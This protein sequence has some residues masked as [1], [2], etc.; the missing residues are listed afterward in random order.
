MRIDSYHA[1]LNNGMIITN[2]TLENE[3]IKWNKMH[4]S[5]T[6]THVKKNRVE[7]KDTLLN[8]HIELETQ[9][10]TET[11]S[12]QEIDCLEISLEIEHEQILA[13]YLF[14]DW[15]T[16]PLFISSFKE[17]PEQTTVLFFKN[18]DIYTCMLALPGKVFRAH[19]ASGDADNQVKLVLSS[20]SAGYS[21]IEETSLVFE[22]DAN[23]YNCFKK[24]I[25][26]ACELYHIP[27]RADRVY[28]SLFEKIGW[29]SWDAFYKEVNEEKLVKKANEIKSKQIPFGWILIDDGWQDYENDQM[30]SYKTN[31]VKFPNELI[32]VVNKIEDITGID[33]VGVWH[34]F[35]GYWSGVHPTG[36][37]LKNNPDLFIHTHQGKIMP[38]PEKA[39]EFF[40]EWYEYLKSQKISFVKVDSQSST[41]Q[42]YRS[43]TPTGLTSKYLHEG[44][45][46]ASETYMDGNL[47]NCMGMALEDVLQ[48][49]I[50]GLSRN[51]D[52]FFPLEEKSFKEHLLEN[53]Y[54]SLY[55]NYIYYADWDM[56]WSNHK[57]AN[58]HALLRALS[59]GPIYVS[60]KI[61]ETIPEVLMPTCYEDGTILRANQSA[62]PTVDCILMDPEKNGYLKIQN[63][64]NGVGYMAIYSYLNR[65]CEVSIQVKDISLL[66][67]NE[68]Y[69]IYNPMDKVGF[70]GNKET[71]WNI[72][73]PCEGYTFYQIAPIIDGIAVFGRSDKYLSSHAIKR[74]GSTIRLKESGP[75]LFY[76]EKEPSMHC[77]NLG[78][79]FY[80]IQLPIDKKEIELEI[81]R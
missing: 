48:R 65:D 56:F 75:V 15:W 22:R 72:Q 14:K 79:H 51:S 9:S 32:S 7:L 25:E 69:A 27:I 8:V 20:D 18:K 47:I 12:F 17:V 24:T 52:D 73:L 42:Q 53:A 40:K 55:H 3:I 13:Y 77:I 38:K 19:F 29:C 58:K 2:Q 30:K 59:G 44:L 39:K 81:R 4:W 45:D 1:K 57:Y 43:N 11:M 78:N 21:S 61:N 23:P 33:K 70:V 6:Q 66:E 60:D 26:K 36:E 50:S 28:P 41:R 34:A 74:N 35:S 10:F 67:D 46:W 68:T 5:P 31:S 63:E 62:I 76:S 16:R 37:L 80:E 71:K 64:C 54:N 49:P